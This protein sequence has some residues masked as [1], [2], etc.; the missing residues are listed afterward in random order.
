MSINKNTRITERTIFEY[1]VRDYNKMLVKFKEL[2]IREMPLEKAC[3][4]LEGYNLVQGDNGFF[5]FDS[6]WFIGTVN[7][8]N[9]YLELSN[10]VEIYDFEGDLVG[11]YDIN[12]LEK[13]I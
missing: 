2:N 13:F 11:Q 4:T 10:S 5:D 7:L 9:G 12:K 1:V 8:K 3:D 6:K